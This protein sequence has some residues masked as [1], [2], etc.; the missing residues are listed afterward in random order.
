LTHTKNVKCHFKGIAASK[1][2]NRRQSF[3][4]DFVRASTSFISRSFG[5]PS[6]TNEAKPSHA[7]DTF[8]VLAVFAR[9]LNDH[10]IRAMRA[11]SQSWHSDF[12]E[13]S[14]CATGFRSITKLL[15]EPLEST[16][17]ISAVCQ[18]RRLPLSETI[19]T[20]IFAVLGIAITTSHPNHICGWISRDVI[21]AKRTRA[22]IGIAIHFI[23]CHSNF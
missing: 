11:R 10:R 22:L 20:K 7:C 8:R 19:P 15:V 12:I 17:R 3:W 14:L 4:T 13:Q 23:F 18:T 21:V 2:L 16:P 6:Q 1:L 5:I 9:M